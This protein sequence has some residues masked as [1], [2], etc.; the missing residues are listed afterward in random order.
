MHAQQHMY[1]IY[2]VSYNP[3]NSGGS[4]HGTHWFVSLYSGFPAAYVHNSG[5]SLHGTHW[6]VSLYSGLIRSGRLDHP[7]KPDR[8]CFPSFLVSDTSLLPSTLTP[9]G[10]YEQ[11]DS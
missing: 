4:L 7:T 9:P 3:H 10:A 6:F 2:E 1:I 5:G 11:P 8:D